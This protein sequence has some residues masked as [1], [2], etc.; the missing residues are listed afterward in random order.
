MPLALN[1]GPASVVP[2]KGSP[3]VGGEVNA[4]V[5]VAR[6]VQDGY[7]ELE[8][9]GQRTRQSPALAHVVELY[10]FLVGALEERPEVVLAHRPEGLGLRGLGLLLHVC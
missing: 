1:F 6:L 10:D 7:R 3:K 5:E 9:E 4:A 2:C 8:G